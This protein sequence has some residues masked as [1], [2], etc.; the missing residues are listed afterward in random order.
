LLEIEDL[1]DHWRRRI[2]VIAG[3]GT[4]EEE[5]CGGHWG[6]RIVVI[7]AGRGLWSSVK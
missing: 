7:V 5:D 2:L 4:L 1:C 6:R 3:G